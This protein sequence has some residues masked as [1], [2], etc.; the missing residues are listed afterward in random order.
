MPLPITVF[1]THRLRCHTL[2]EIRM[3]T[4]GPDCTMRISVPFTHLLCEY[5]HT[6]QRTLWRRSQRAN[7]SVQSKKTSTKY[8]VFRTLPRLLRFLRISR[9]CCQACK[10]RTREYQLYTNDRLPSNDA[11]PR[12]SKICH[13]LCESRDPISHIVRISTHATPVQACEFQSKLSQHPSVC[14]NVRVYLCT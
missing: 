2:P 11:N 7:I 5:Q 3:Y 12:Y 9:S 10:C 1:R 6:P 14:A 4:S 13:R 8:T